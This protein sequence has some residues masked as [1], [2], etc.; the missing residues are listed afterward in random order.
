MVLRTCRTPGMFLSVHEAVRLPPS[1]MV[2]MEPE[3]ESALMFVILADAAVFPARLT[4]SEREERERERR[5]LSLKDP[6]GCGLLLRSSSDVTNL[7]RAT[8]SV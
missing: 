5:R 3:G 8:R 4:E 1:G 7:S 2:G 6:R